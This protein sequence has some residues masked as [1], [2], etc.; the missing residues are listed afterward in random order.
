MAFTT[1]LEG[2]TTGTESYIATS[3]LGNHSLIATV[4]VVQGIVI[5][6]LT[7]LPSP[8]FLFSLSVLFGVVCS[9]SSDSAVIKPPMAK[10]ADV[11]GRLEAYCISILLYVLGNIQQ[12]TAQIFLSF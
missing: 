11:F 4:Y 1:S 5:G 8:L 12:A 3:E 7:H 6:N 9:Y 2:K 10:I